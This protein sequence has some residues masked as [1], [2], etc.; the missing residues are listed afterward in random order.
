MSIG[1]ASLA[2]MIDVREGW[3]V[4]WSSVLLIRFISA[5]NAHLDVG[6][7]ARAAKESLYRKELFGKDILAS[8]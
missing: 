2:F 1:T 7:K 3:I 6:G 8:M 4:I 5:A